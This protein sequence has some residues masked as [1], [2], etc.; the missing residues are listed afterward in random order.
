MYNRPKLLNIK[1]KH[2]KKIIILL[3]ALGLT[4][5]GAYNS[6]AFE[7]GIICRYD[8]E[9]KITSIHDHAYYVNR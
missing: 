2:M 7:E 6:I 9:C 1:I 3:F 8:S 5:C 4:S